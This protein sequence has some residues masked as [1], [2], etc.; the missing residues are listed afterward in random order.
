MY[1][2][3]ALCMAASVQQS[4]PLCGSTKGHVLHLHGALL[5]VTSYL[6]AQAVCLLATTGP[7]C[8][9]ASM[10]RNLGTVVAYSIIFTS[11]CVLYLPRSLLWASVPVLL[12]A[13]LRRAPSEYLGPGKRAQRGRMSDAELALR[14]SCSVSPIPGVP[15]AKVTYQVAGHLHTRFSI[16]GAELHSSRSSAGVNIACCQ[17]WNDEADPVAGHYVAAQ[18]GPTRAA[19]HMPPLQARS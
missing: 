16:S 14:L 19:M 11:R 12:H 15:A 7:D 3:L 8:M 2:V 6:V 5:A 17:G 9:Q 1:L 13:S 4:K 10:W 18:A